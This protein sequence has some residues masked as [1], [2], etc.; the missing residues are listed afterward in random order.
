MGGTAHGASLPSGAGSPAARRSPGPRA[1]GGAASPE[2]RE[3]PPPAAS[4]LTGAKNFFFIKKI[5]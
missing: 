3:F 5:F 4:A 2:P 1:A